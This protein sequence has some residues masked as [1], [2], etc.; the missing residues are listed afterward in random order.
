MKTNIY[1]TVLFVLI[2]VVFTSCSDYLDVQPED[3][4]L[5]DQ[6]YNSESGTN[7][8]LNG[9]YLNLTDKK[10][11]GG[12]LTMSTIELLAQR[13]NA[14]ET[15][16]N[17]AN[18]AYQENNVKENFDDIWTSA[19][20]NILNLNDLIANVE[21]YNI[22]TPFKTSIIKGEA[23]GLRAMLHFDMLRLFGPVY[24]ENPDN[25]AIPYYTKTQAKNGE[26]LPADQV[27]ENIVADLTKAE[28]L[29]DEDPIRQNGVN[30]GSLE[31]PFY[32]NNRNLR[33][34]FF[35]V[36]A[37]QARVYLYAGNAVEANKAAKVVI[38][39]ASSFFPWTDPTDVVSAGS[40]PDR[41]FSSE[42]IFAMQNVELYERQNDFFSSSL[43]D[44]NILAPNATRLR[45]V[46]ENNENDYR[47]TSTWIYPAEKTYRTFYKYADI[48]DSRL[49]FRYLQPLIR[50][51]EMYYIAA[52]TE[53]DETLALQYL[54]TV[55]FNRGLV[56]LT[57]EININTELEKEYQKE[58]F[59]EGQLF[60]YYKR[61]NIPRILNGSSSSSFS[62]ITMDESKY[63]VPLPDSETKYQ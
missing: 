22:L 32:Y 46:F 25:L 34:N 4:L 23:Y 52:E 8:V 59:G 13:Y 3:K 6:I 62:R 16:Y 33:F 47:Y 61:R 36:K 58:F 29:L 9:I 18:Y 60:F 20:T 39:E 24:S 10:L 43:I 56:D 49:L 51:S 2:A 30:S 45:N 42:V 41:T 26:I 35:A 48:S 55:R 37:L 54:N 50:I 27:L 28:E 44:N 12:N 31:A 7:N 21:K 17:F 14:S 5:E 38:D 1:K 53:T 63:V 15:Y 19:Y 57:S 40:N 11:Y